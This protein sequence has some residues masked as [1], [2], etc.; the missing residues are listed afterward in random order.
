MFRV[1]GARPDAVTLAAARVTVEI[2]VADRCTIDVA[3]DIRVARTGRCAEYTCMRTHVA[4]LHLR[5]ALETIDQVAATPGETPFG[6]I[7]GKVD[8]I[9]LGVDQSGNCAAEVKHAVAKWK[10]LHPAKLTENG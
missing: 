4:F 6:G 5:N 2:H 9:S 7:G 8:K 3:R 1:R 10:N